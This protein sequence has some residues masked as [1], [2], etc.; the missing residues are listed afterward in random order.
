MIFKGSI[1]TMTRRLFFMVLFLLLF[2]K[3]FAQAPNWVVNGNSFQYSMTIVGFLTMD[4]VTLSSTND[5]VAAFVNGQCRGV[6]NLIYVASQKGYYAYLT[7]FS[8]VNGEI[9]NFK[10]YNSVNNAVKDIGVA[11]TFEIGQNYGN[12]FQAFSFANPALSSAAEI[13]DFNFKDIVRKGIQFDGSKVMI[14]LDKMQS[15]VSLNSLFTLSPGASAYIGTA[16]QLSGSNSINFTNPVVFKV[17]SQDQS[18][19]KEWIVSVQPPIFYYRKNVVCYAKG[20][21]KV[22]CPWEGTSVALQFNGQ[23]L[24]SQTI[25]N[26]ETTFTNL[27][28]G[29]YKVITLGVVKEINVIQ[30]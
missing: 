17:L 4:G 19:L 11:K 25:V 28:A 18:V 9:V 24:A 23:T 8:N 16:P 21:I 7:V 29:V 1:F 22:V 13:L 6:T 5:K 26:G 10:I 2:T 14:T 15:V 3:S 30:K 20:A 27:I 12:L